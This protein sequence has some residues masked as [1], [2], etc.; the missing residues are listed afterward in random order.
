LLR[1]DLELEATLVAKYAA[2]SSLLNE[3]ARRLWAAAESVAIG[4]GGDAVVSSATGLAPTTIRRGRRQLAEGGPPT[5]RLRRPGAGRPGVETSQPGLTTALEALVEPVTRGDP[6]SPLRWTCKSKAKLAAALTAQGW[7]V[8]AT[9]V[10]R[11]L[12]DLGYRLQALQKTLEGTSHPD[13]NAQ[14]EHINATATA[15]L[16]RKQPVI[17]VDTKKKELVG[18]FKTAGQEWQP[19]GQPEPVRVHDFPEDALGKAIPYGVYDMARNE[20]WVNVGRD[21][22][23]PAFAV[24]SIRQW[25]TMMGRR[26]YPAATALYITADAGGSNG[27]RS[28]A[29]KTGLQR[30]AD[31]LGLT[32]H[33]SHFPPGTS[34]WNEIEHRLFCHLTENWRGRALL[35]FETLVELIG[36]TRTT[37]GLRVKAKLDK[38]RYK[39]GVVVTKDEMG[40]LALQPHVFHGDWNYAIRPRST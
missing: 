38:R 30:L 6:T 27:Y 19:T 5:P 31:D 32:I 18:N 13:R 20:A 25:W 3:R 16:R 36:H 33:V 9:T 40:D 28:R 34:K 4:Y 29:W 24:A 26:A 2:L 17:S 15:F 1:R 14:F 39:T 22:D 37:T 12:H 11:L 7:R 23:T 10:G 35:T 21:H 8:S